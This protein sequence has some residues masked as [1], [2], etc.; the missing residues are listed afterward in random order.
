MT[1]LL[2]ERTRRFRDEV[3][4]LSF[5][6][7]L[8][9]YNPLVYAWDLHQEFLE[10]YCRQDARMLWLG[11]N[12]GP[13]GM[14]QDGVP[15]GEVGAVRGYLHMD[16]TVRQPLRMHPKR[17][18]LGLACK[19][20]EGSGKRLWGYLAARWP[21]PM[22]MARHVMVL[23]YCPLVFMDAGP[24][25]KNVTPDAL[26]VRCRQALEE[27]CDRYVR[28]VLD[29]SQAP[30]LVGVGKYAGEKLARLAPPGRHVGTIVHPSPANP[31]ANRGWD[32]LVDAALV[33]FQNSFGFVP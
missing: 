8:Y 5:P 25:G 26:P 27:V 7:S 17:P 12:P 13:F 33:S 15:F 31:Q 9:V 3:E 14:A 28:D 6:E 1:N 19:R 16:G 21:D 10:R 30:M 2:I 11:M 4:A 18:V 32:A 22:E 23:N 20:S 29:W 24:T